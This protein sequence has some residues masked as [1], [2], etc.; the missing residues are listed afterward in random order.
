MRRQEGIAFLCGAHEAVP[1]SLCLFPDQPLL[2]F[3]FLPLRIGNQTYLMADFPEPQIRIV[4]PQQQTVLGPAGHHTIGLEALLRHQIINQ[5]ANIG[6]R[7]IQYHRLSAQALH[8]RID[9]CHQSLYRSLLIAAGAVELPAGKETVNVLEFQ[10]AAKLCGIDAV[11]FNGIGISDDP[12][13]F[14]ALHAAVHLILHI[15]RQRGGHTG[16]VHL[17]GIG[18]LRFH[19]D[20]MPVLVREFHDLV[21]NRRAIPGTGALDTAVIHRRTVY[22]FPND[23]VGLLIGIHQVA[24]HLLLLHLLKF[25]GEG[26]GNHR[27]I[28]L[29]H[30]HLG[31]VQGSSVHPGR[32]TGLEAQHPH[33]LRQQRIRQLRGPPQPVGTRIL[34]NI[35]EDAAGVQINTGTEH[36]CPGMIDST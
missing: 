2:F 27:H 3:R 28:S 33:A 26:E 8:G 14:K 18:S 5:H 25:R 12:H 34:R 22:I 32:G 15:L 10:A 19:E 23:F 24:V 30:L 7:T 6:L 31:K 4:L 13:V 20:L 17:V 16:K 21:F 1:E 36:H 35:A 29:L 11:V 9:A